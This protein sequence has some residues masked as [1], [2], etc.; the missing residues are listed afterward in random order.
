[1]DFKNTFFLRGR[2][3]ED[4]G[5]PGVILD[6]CGRRSEIGL[7]WVTHRKSTVASA[8]IARSS[9]GRYACTPP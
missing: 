6:Y 9:E 2:V 7:G 8:A 4:L 5:R 3:D 1:M